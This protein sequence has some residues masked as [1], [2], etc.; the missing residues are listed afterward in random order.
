M[1]NEKD[2]QN[3]ISELE[4]ELKVYKEE[5]LN[6]TNLNSILKIF[7]DNIDKYCSFIWDR[8]TRFRKIESVTEDCI[9]FSQPKFLMATGILTVDWV[10]FN[11]EKVNI[12]EHSDFFLTIKNNIKFF[13][14]EELKDH[15]RLYMENVNNM[16]RL[17]P[18]LTDQFIPFSGDDV[19]FGERKE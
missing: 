18:I 3:K 5:V 4:K 14:A 9:E 12:K 17:G 13:T 2:Y 7:T 6:T 16:T 8:M 1:K 11:K 10:Y 15:T 19:Y